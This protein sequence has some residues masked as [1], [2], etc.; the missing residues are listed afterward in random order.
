MARPLSGRAKRKAAEKKAARGDYVAKFDDKGNKV[1]VGKPTTKASVTANLSKGSKRPGQ[2]SPKAKAARAAAAKPAPASAKPKQSFG[3]A[4]AAAREKQ[5]SRGTFSWTN[6]KTGKTDKY[7]TRRE[8]D[9]ARARAGAKP[10]RVVKPKGPVKL[11]KSTA[12]QRT[13]RVAARRSAAAKP[14]TSRMSWPD[15]RMASPK[16]KPTTKPK[17][18][19]KP[20]A[21]RGGRTNYRSAASRRRGGR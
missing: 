8:D 4:F 5:G 16:A 17:P 6:P 14:A 18:K 9:T 2:A 11:G 12:Q 7:T 10:T 13:E 21:R 20:T 1:N 15:A 3:S 19:P